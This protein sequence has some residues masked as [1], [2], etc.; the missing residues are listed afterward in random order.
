[1]LA[2]GV[3]IAACENNGVI[4]VKIKASDATTA[5]ELL[6]LELSLTTKF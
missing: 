3:E 5:T 2:V 1:M 6:Y 4:I